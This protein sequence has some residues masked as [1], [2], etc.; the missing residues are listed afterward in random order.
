MAWMFWIIFILACGIL[1]GF[2]LD[3][4]LSEFES[5]DRTE[6]TAQFVEPDGD[7]RQAGEGT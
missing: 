4:I 1:C 5:A 2:A 6:V 3:P 7:D